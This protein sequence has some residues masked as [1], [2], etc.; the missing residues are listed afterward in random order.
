M[1]KWQQTLESET[2]LRDLELSDEEVTWLYHDIQEATGYSIRYYAVE[3]YDKQIFNIFGF[4]AD[5]SLLLVAGQGGSNPEDDFVVI[6]YV[7]QSGREL[8]FEDDSITD[9]KEGGSH[10]VLRRQGR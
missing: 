8:T 6:K 5:K 4:L 9:K 10:E 7:T 1:K 2:P 3:G